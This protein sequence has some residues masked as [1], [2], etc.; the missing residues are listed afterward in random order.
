MVAL[1]MSF[2]YAFLFILFTAG[3]TAKFS[4]G[5]VDGQWRVWLKYP[6]LFWAEVVGFSIAV[7]FLTSFFK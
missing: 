5:K 3:V 7:L 2:Y 1:G 6:L 4:V